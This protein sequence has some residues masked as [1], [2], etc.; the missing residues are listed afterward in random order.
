MFLHRSEGAADEQS[1]ALVLMSHS[2]MRL[3]SCRPTRDCIH[4]GLARGASSGWIETTWSL[5]E[6]SSMPARQSDGSAGD[7]NYGVVGAGYTNCRQPE[8]AIAAMI[9]A[10][11]GC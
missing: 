1:D 4:I 7:T 8:P 6:G 3:L 10:P 11:C 9:L 5:G 2:I